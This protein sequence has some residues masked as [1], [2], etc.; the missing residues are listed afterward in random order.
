[1]KPAL[2][3]ALFALAFTSTV[4]SQEM[5]DAG[6]AKD[7]ASGCSFKAPRSLPSGPT[8]WIGDCTGGKATGL[9]VLRRRDGTVAGEA[10]Y[11]ELK[12]GVPV[13]GVIDTRRDDQGGFVLG[14]WKDG[15]LVSN[16]DNPWQDR[17]DA[18]T[19]AASAARAAS[20]VF[21]S[22]KNEVSA[23]FYAQQAEMLAEQ[24]DG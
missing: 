7:P 11:G 16:D 14:R 9:G 17:A 5:P 19:T 23:S 13:I 12:N 3:S 22:Q 10:F 20:A 21:R 18:F 24:L 4:A 1:M 8:Y 6:W 2:L 15:D